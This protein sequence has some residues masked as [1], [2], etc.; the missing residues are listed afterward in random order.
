MIFPYFTGVTNL[1]MAMTQSED[2]KT[3]AP[4]TAQILEW[5]LGA[6]VA[7]LS[8]FA[9]NRFMAMANI[10]EMTDPYTATAMRSI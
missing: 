6:T 3:N 1:F 10:I 4:M 7:M 5:L 2:M 8:L 9:L